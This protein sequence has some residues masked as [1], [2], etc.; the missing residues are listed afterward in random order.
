MSTESIRDALLML[1][2]E[3]HFNIITFASTT[4]KMSDSMLPANL[5]NIEKSFKY[6]RKFTPQSTRNNLGTDLLGAIDLSLQFNP[7]VIVLVTDGL[8]TPGRVKSRQIETAPDKIIKAVKTKNVNHASIYV[9]GLEMTLKEV[10]YFLSS[11]EGRTPSPKPPSEIDVDTK[12]I[13]I[14]RREFTN[15]LS[16]A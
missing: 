13:K 15:S 7:S 11:I 14:A 6:L 8:P 5:Q 12:N 1:K 16:K 9:I 10:T 3:D 4:K 2:E